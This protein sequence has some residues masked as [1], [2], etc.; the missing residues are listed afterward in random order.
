ME[1]LVG[2]EMG[3]NLDELLYKSSI[4][5]EEGNLLPIL[6]KF[7]LPNLR[8]KICVQN[9]ILAHFVNDHPTMEEEM[10]KKILEHLNEIY[11]SGKRMHLKLVEYKRNRNDNSI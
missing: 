9:L 4:F 10:K 7:L 3:T 11:K 1:K 5:D 8:N 2:G 6:P